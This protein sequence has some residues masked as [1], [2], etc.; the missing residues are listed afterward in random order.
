M[1]CNNPLDVQSRLQ[2]ACNGA[3]IPFVYWMQDFQ[4]LEIDRM[5][6]GRGAIMNIV[7]GGYYHGLERKL[8]QRSEA[9][10]HAVRLGLVVL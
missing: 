7:V 6:A 1:A 4:S 10:V 5:I 3:S 8:L 2:A 9:I